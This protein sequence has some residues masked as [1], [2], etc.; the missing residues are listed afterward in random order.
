MLLWS[1]EAVLVG[2]VVATTLKL[3]DFPR[4]G[5][6][7]DR[8]ETHPG[9][10][11]WPKHR[12]CRLKRIGRADLNAAAHD[13]TRSRRPNG[14]IR[15]AGAGEATS[16]TALRS[17]CESELISRQPDTGIHNFPCNL[18]NGYRAGI[19]RGGA[20]HPMHARVSRAFFHG[21]SDG[22]IVPHSA[23][24]LKRGGQDKN[25]RDADQSE[26][27]SGRSAPAVSAT[28]SHGCTF[29]LIWAFRVMVRL[30]V[31]PGMGIMLMV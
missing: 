25:E 30:P 26:F 1:I 19:W 31:T 9:S 4:G 8:A 11:A 5:W 16:R 13:I 10:G 27:K 18:R 20:I 29:S 15:E 3:N 17:K 23:G 24:H 7:I 12:N 21:I 6:E 28:G 14:W 2:T 22:V